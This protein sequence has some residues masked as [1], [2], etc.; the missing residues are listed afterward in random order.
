MGSFYFIPAKGLKIEFCF[1]DKDNIEEVIMQDT[2]SLRRF[3]EK[4]KKERG[5]LIKD[6]LSL[7]KDFSKFVLKVMLALLL[8]Y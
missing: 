3:L 7:S 1:V 5:C 2:I 4:L 6:H 8:A